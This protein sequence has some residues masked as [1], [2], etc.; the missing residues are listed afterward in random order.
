MRIRSAIASAL[1][2]VS[3][4]AG[5]QQQP[6]TQP[7]SIPFDLAL[8][9]TSSG[10]L[11]TD[12]DPQILVGAIPEWALNRVP[13][14]T[15]WRAIGSA[16]LGTTVVGVMQIP[17]ANDSLIQRFQ[18]HLERNGWKAPPPSSMGYVGGGFRPA[19]SQ[20]STRRGERRFQVCRENQMV[21]AW[22]AREQPLATTIAFR[23]STPTAGQ[24]NQCNPPAPDPRMVAAARE[25][26]FPVLYD[27]A[28]R[29]PMSMNSCFTQEGF[30]SGRTETRYKATMTAEQ[31][32]DH[33]ARQL[34]D[35]GWM[36]AGAGRPTISRV[37]TR[38]APSG[39][40]RQLVLT[41]SGPAGAD[42]GCVRVQMEAPS[43][44]P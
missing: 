14:P 33:Y 20:A 26:P 25:S 10:G 43:G 17:T 44:R 8:A 40:P 18:Q 29:D 35:S 12:S 21:N 5:A 31:V 39:P 16:F 2:V 22:I 15:G 28:L 13:L 6:L 7:T 32:L 23:L 19:L 11:G 34:A 4:S 9:L 3:A 1:V 36:V 37:W 27:P 30:G 38:S 41:V 42:T 24:F